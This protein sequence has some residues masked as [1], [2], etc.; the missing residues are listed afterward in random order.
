MTCALG[1]AGPTP[2]QGHFVYFK[3]LVLGFIVLRRC[4]GLLFFK[5]LCSR[6]KV[7]SRESCYSSIYGSRTDHTMAYCSSR[8]YCQLRTRQL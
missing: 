8:T 7:V 2:I 1:H 5:V 6:A 3:G 4:L